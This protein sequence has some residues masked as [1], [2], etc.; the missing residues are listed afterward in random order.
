MTVYIRPQLRN[1]SPKQPTHTPTHPLHPNPHRNS[2]VNLDYAI[3]RICVKSF[4][5]INNVD[6]SMNIQGDN[7]NGTN[8][9]MK[10]VEQHTESFSALETKYNEHI[11]VIRFYTT[12]YMVQI[13]V[14]IGL[15][16]TP[17][18]YAKHK[19][20]SLVHHKHD[21]S[22]NVSH[23]TSVCVSDLK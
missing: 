19:S 12:W 23:N 3:E 21:A 11:I 18:R 2:S 6:T 13:Q 8:V 22:H 7:S 9:W 17:P 10:I 1:N 4:V 14:Q 16:V 20:T 5:Y 15:Q